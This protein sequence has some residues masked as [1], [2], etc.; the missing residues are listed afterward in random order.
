MDEYEKQVMEMMLD[1]GNNFTHERMAELVRAFA[2]GISRTMA[3]IGDHDMMHRAVHD[4]CDAIQKD[5]CHFHSDFHKL[6]RA[7]D[8]ETFLRDIYKPE[9]PNA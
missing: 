8:A 2:A 6:K 5:A 4:L 1:L 9:V 7:M 3:L